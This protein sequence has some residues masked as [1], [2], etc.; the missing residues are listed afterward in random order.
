M[1]FG[2]SSLEFNS[3]SVVARDV[4]RATSTSTVFVQSLV[5]LLQDL[6]VAAHAEVVVSAPNGD[7]LLL[8]GHV[9][10]GKLLGQ[11]VDVVEVA[12][13]L[14]LVL[15][16]ELRGIKGVVVELG[17]VGGGGARGILAMGGHRRRGMA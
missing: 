8:V 11:A 3:M 15:L 16:I 7:T 12:V 2:Q 9:G 14:V 13:G 6:G 10:A 4:A 5:H 1:E 17:E